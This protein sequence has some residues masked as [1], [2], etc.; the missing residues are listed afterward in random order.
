MLAGRHAI[1]LNM[2]LQENVSLR[3]YCTIRLGGPAKYFATAKTPKDIKAAIDFANE[4]QI[5]F[6]CLGSGAN[7]IFSDSGYDGLILK[8]EISGFEVTDEN[9][10]NT[11]VKVGAG[12]NWD[13][14]VRRTVELGL[15]G[16]ETLSAIPGTAGAAPVQNIGAYGQEL[17]D[18][19]VELDA[20][21][22]K[23]L[24]QVVLKPEDCKFGY[25]ASIFKSDAPERYIITSITLKLNKKSLVPPFYASLER[26]LSEHD[27][28]D[29]SPANIRAAV[30][31][32]RKSKLPDPS[33][34]ANSGS[35]FQNPIIPK[36]QVDE[37]L[38]EHP[39]MPHY[40]VSSDSEKVPA[41]WLIEEAGLRGLKSGHFSTYNL[42]A[43][44]ITH[45]GK[46]TFSEL[47]DFIKIIQAKVNEKFGIEIKPEP[48]LII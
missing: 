25:R 29:Y 21:D 7:V 3:D 18:T 13:E 23:Q 30:I 15:S 14:V 11:T 8:I 45:D 38:K 44:V 5:N 39:K 10:T 19:F 47:Q 48:Q 40:T 46:G 33:L 34:I 26:Y 32:I 36:S 4:K 27:I 6:F 43:L 28:T 1:L 41:G 9:E 17:K 37:L 16:I 12:E 2:R 22:R 35:F 24:K 42:H 20:Y 31:E